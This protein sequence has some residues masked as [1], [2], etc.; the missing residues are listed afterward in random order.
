MVKIAIRDDDMNFFT[1]VE[2]VERLYNPI[3]E[4]PISFAVIPAV[5]DVSTVGACSDTRGNKEPR[6]VGDNKQLMEWLRKQLSDKKCDV[7]MHGINHNYQ[8]TNGVREAEM[9]W[10]EEENLAET[11]KYWRERMSDDLNYPINCFVAPSNKITKYGIQSITSNKLN[12]S[13]IIPIGF[14][15]E[16]T[17]LNIMNYCKRWFLRM[18]D[19]LPYP[20]VLS[21]SSHKEVNA[22]ILQSYDYLVKMFDYCEQ[23]EWPRV[24]NVHYWQL[25]DNKDTLSDLYKFVEY[26]LSKGAHGS[27]ISDIL[28]A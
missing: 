21:Y 3:L 6:Y 15:R 22:C 28:K 10:R 5:I 16:I 27:T 20:G 24:V 1:K 4:I 7:L 2:D 13:G 9:E 19:G 23:K 25:R 18:K 11:I 12:Y 14:K 8:I 26:A 17:V